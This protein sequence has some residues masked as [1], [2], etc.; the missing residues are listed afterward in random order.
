MAKGCPIGGAAKPGSA[1]G[2]PGPGGGI[3]RELQIP[4]DLVGGLIGPGGATINDIRQ[5]AGGWAAS[6]VGP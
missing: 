6:G 2:V 5:K 1:V 3:P 4:H